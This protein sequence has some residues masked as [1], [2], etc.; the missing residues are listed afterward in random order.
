MATATAS[1][2]AVPTADQAIA[3]ID[4]WQPH[5]VIFD[6][7]IGGQQIMQHVM[8]RPAGAQRLPT[9]ASLDAAI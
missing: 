2:R 9:I 4:E 7:D 6:A 3:A 1:T 8:A 5:L